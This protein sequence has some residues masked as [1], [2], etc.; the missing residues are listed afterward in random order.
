MSL[1][2][3]HSQQLS[4]KVLFVLYCLFSSGYLIKHWL[5][6]LILFSVYFSYVFC[7]FN[8]S[9]LYSSLWL[10]W[11]IFIVLKY[12]LLI[13][14]FQNFIWLLSKC[15]ISVF[16]VFCRY[17]QVF[18]ISFAHRRQSNFLICVWWCLCTML[19]S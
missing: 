16:L 11:H 10:F 8:S 5:S 3:E 19:W 1:V 17:F 18:K 12:I 7:T 15:T 4:F 13:L 9:V 6:R 14:Q 2:L